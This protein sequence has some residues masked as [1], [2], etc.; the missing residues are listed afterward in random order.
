ME[1]LKLALTRLCEETIS[2]FRIHPGLHPGE[3][4]I[5]NKQRDEQKD[6]LRGKF[7]VY[8]NLPE[9]ESTPNL[10]QKTGVPK[11]E[12][13]FTNNGFSITFD[14]KL[15]INEI[16]AEIRSHTEAEPRVPENHLL[17]NRCD[18][19]LTGREFDEKLVHLSGEEVKDASLATELETNNPA[20]IY[21]SRNSKFQRKQQGSKHKRFVCPIANCHQELANSNT[22]R[23]HMNSH[24]GLMPYK[25]PGCDKGFAWN[26]TLHNHKKTCMNLPKKFKCET[27][28]REFWR[29]ADF[30][31]HQDTHTGEKPFACKICKKSFRSAGN[32][33]R[34]EINCKE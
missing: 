8:L 26:S 16:E 34:H 24:Q 30:M 14:Q 1:D 25:C 10:Q 22:F 6:R 9:M 19:N 13:L 29:K 4:H 33:K 12:I 31:Y 15:I 17:K 27:C 2:Q 11:N 3:L 18:E 23:Y 20:D 5:D 21:T 7:Q 28:A 32:M